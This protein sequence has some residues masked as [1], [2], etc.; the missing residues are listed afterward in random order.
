M[1]VLFPRD[2]FGSFLVM[3]LILLWIERT[4]WFDRKEAE[5]CDE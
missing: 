1:L 4:I 3:L 5:D 2:P